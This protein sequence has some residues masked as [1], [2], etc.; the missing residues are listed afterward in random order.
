MRS[1]SIFKLLIGVALIFVG[2]ISFAQFDTVKR[3]DNKTKNGKLTSMTK[4]QVVVTANGVDEET[5]V[6]EIL[7][8][9]FAGEPNELKTS[10]LNV[11]NGH[12]EETKKT[13]AKID[14]DNLQREVVQNEVRFYLALCNAK[15]AMMG[16]VPVDAAIKEMFSFVKANRDNYHYYEACQALGDLSVRKGDFGGASKYYGL[17][18]KAP[19][20]EYQMRA[21]VL[22][23]RASQA[24]GDDAGA[25]KKFDFVLGQKTTSPKEEGWHLAAKLGKAVSLTAA[26]PEKA[27]EAIAVV[28]QVI[29]K[30]A[31]EEKDLH[32]RAYNALGKCYLQNNATKDALLAFLRVDVLYAAHAQEHAEALSHL[33][34]LWKEVGKEDRSREASAVLKDRYPNTKWAQ[35]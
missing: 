27:D 24:N 22:A 31:P 6:N 9:S 19:W 7:S 28:L 15:L 10:R 20:P 11:R 4:N 18:R 23:G 16:S 29:K 25:V 35:Q 34:K 13:L 1:Q 32:A 3:T 14:V 17:L 2:S 30:A 5:P 33:V 26:N 12:Y 8:V 21:G